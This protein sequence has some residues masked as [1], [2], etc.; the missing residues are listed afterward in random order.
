MDRRGRDGAW[1]GVGLVT[2]MAMYVTGNVWCVLFLL[3]VALAY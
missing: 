3:L 1:I 2:A